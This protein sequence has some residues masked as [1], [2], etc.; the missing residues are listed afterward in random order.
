MEM[1][2]TTTTTTA[3]IIP[4]TDAERGVNV[5]LMIIWIIMIIAKWLLWVGHGKEEKE[6]EKGGRK[7]GDF[8]IAFLFRISQLQQLDD[9]K[10]VW[11]VE[12]FAET[13]SLSPSPHFPPTDFKCISM[14]TPLSEHHRID[15]VLLWKMWLQG[16]KGSRGKGGKGGGK[17][18]INVGK[19][20]SDTRL[21]LIDNQS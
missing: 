7:G 8:L 6:E 2:N 17:L 11:I 20:A 15:D 13:S 12:R 14:F 16:E 18:K 5:Y 10:L 9:D 4:L 1:R 3:K 19:G 21:E